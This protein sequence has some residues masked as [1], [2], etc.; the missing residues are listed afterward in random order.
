MSWKEQVPAAL[1]AAAIDVAQT[2]R[3]LC[4]VTPGDPQFALAMGG[5]IGDSLNRACNAMGLHF[6]WVFG[7]FI[8]KAKETPL[9]LRNSAQA[10][11]AEYLRAVAIRLAGS[12]R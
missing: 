9:P 10:T 1:D 2:E 12:G 6:D 5:L 11:A 7:V 4:S 8:E 3:H